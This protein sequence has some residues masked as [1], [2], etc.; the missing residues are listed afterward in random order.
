LTIKIDTKEFIRR[1]KAAHGDRYDYSLSKY[2]S[3]H[4]KVK[5]ICPVHG[6]FEQSAKHHWEGH[7]CGVCGGRKKLTRDEFIERSGKVHNFK[8]DYS[9]TNLESLNKKVI[10]ICPVH[11]KFQQYA[12]HHIRGHGCRRCDF[13]SRIKSTEQFISDSKLVHGDR[14]D[15]SKSKYILN[16]KPTIIICKEHGEFSQTPNSHLSGNGCIK[17]AGLERR[18]TKQ[19][20]EDARAIHGDYYDYSHVDYVNSYTKVAIRC[21]RHGYFEQA[22]SGHI[23]GYGCQKC[24][25]LRQTE[26]IRKTT[27]WFI[28]KAVSVH[29]D[30]Y[31][32]S[33]IDYKNLKTKVRIICPEHGEFEQQAENHLRGHGCSYCSGNAK[34]TEMFIKDAIKVHGD[35]YDYSLVEYKGSNKPVEIICEK[36]GLFMQAAAGHLSG[37]GCDKC[38]TQIRIKKLLKFKSTDE[39]IKAAKEVHGDKYDYS[40][41]KYEGGDLKIRIIC[42]EHGP[43]EQIPYSHLKGFGCAACTG[44]KKKDTEQFI[45]EA[46]QLHGDYYDY[47]LVEYVN[48]HTRVLITCPKHGLFQQIARDHLSNPPQCCTRTGFDTEKPALL[49]YLRVANKDNNPLYKIGIT[50]RSVTERFNVLDLGKIEIIDYVKFEKGREALELETEYKRDYSEYRYEGPDI[51]SSGNTELFTIDILELDN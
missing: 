34:N 36:H 23:F 16:S 15:Y 32:Y 25:D 51:L 50:N 1:A 19:F 46:R 45:R 47:S 27:D 4:G 5:I 31:D 20:I 40:Q 6:V 2:K 9:L 7:G 10:I 38:A 29:G 22:P 35:K 14:Y 26:T 21:P 42:P 49:Y 17:C 43:F 8:Y 18:T 48:A 39:F 11:G 28:D 37:S 24:G 13:D 44:M 33:L 3:A 41:S 12:G 30:K